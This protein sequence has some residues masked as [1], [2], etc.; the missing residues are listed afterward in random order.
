VGRTRGFRAGLAGE[1]YNTGRFRGSSR[2]RERAAP[3]PH[4]SL[5]RETMGTP[6]G[7]RYRCSNATLSL[8]GEPKASLRTRLRESSD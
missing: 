4:S 2:R 1:P 8:A 5:A 6:I 7:Y 3:P